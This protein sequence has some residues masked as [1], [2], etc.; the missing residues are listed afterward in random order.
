M[1]SDD[2]LRQIYGKDIPT[3]AFL[4]ISSSNSDAEAR[5]RLAD[6]AKEA[7]R[8]ADTI[9]AL[10]QHADDRI[11]TGSKLR[12]LLQDAADLVHGLAMSNALLRG[13]NYGYEH[14]L[15]GLD[16]H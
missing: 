3:E 14:R 4:I 13:M 15:K 1:I 8:I 10:R 5:A 11:H 12:I 9:A 7:K 2:E 16:E 6:N